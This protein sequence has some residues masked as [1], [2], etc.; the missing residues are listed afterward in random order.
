MRLHFL[1]G[2]CIGVQLDPQLKLSECKDNVR[3][4][5]NV[6]SLTSNQWSRFAD[7]VRMIHGDKNALNKR[8][9]VVSKSRIDAKLKAKTIKH[10]ESLKGNENESI[11]DQ[12][13]HIHIQEYP[14]YHN[15]PLFLPW[16]RAYM[17]LFER[18]LRSVDPSVRLPYWDFTMYH[19]N[20]SNDPALKSTR[21]GG[22]GNPREDNRVDGEFKDL[23]GHFHW[24]GSYKRFITRNH[25]LT[26][27]NPVSPLA[28]LINYLRL[29]DFVFF[30]KHFEASVHGRIHHAIG[31]EFFQH[32]SPNDPLFFAYHSFVDKIWFIWQNMHKFNS[33]GLDQDM[34][35]PFGI[36]VQDVL[37]LEKNVCF[38]YKDTHIFRNGTIQGIPKEVYER[39][40]DYK[41][42][43]QLH[44]STLDMFNQILVDFNYDPKNVHAK[45]GELDDSD[46]DMYDRDILNSD[47]A[48]DV[49]ID[50]LSKDSFGNSP[51]TLP[52]LILSFLFALLK[53]V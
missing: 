23:K 42:D 25:N 22:N 30:S 40:K 37:Y 34:L 6:L 26:D 9:Q 53:L 44:K 33:G 31:Q 14:N 38:S 17:L 7:A 32:S 3:Y 51:S 16:H 19:E 43:G 50:E 28:L 47:R 20:L 49:A 11:Y 36:K 8:I 13:V 5:P 21:F 12:L 10:L 2:I 15:K 24:D 45:A 52:L 48:K 39:F 4:R 27:F 46:S 29:K 18:E 35:E 41:F 1:V